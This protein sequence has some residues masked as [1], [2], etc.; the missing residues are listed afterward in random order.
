MIEIQ[1]TLRFYDAQGQFSI[2]ALEYADGPNPTCNKQLLPLASGDKLEVYDL[3]DLGK[4]AWKGI[5]NYVEGAGSVSHPLSGFRFEDATIAEWSRWFY[6]KQS[7][8]LSR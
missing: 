4:I 3:E 7:A 8:K 1:G 2:P 5:V 6:Y